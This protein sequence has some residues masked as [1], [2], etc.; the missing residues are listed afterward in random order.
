MISKKDFIKINDYLWEIPKSFRPDMRVPARIYVSEKML[1]DV[2]SEA[3]N[4]L[5][6]V[7]SLP[8]IVKYSLAMPDIH[9]GYGVVIGGVAATRYPD[10]VISP[11]GIGFDQNCLPPDAK[12]LLENGTFV[13]IKE[14]ERNWPSQKVQCLNFEKRNLENVKLIRFF[15]QYNNPF[16]YRII[17]S[18][19][20]KIEATKDHP[21]QTKE[22]MK[23]VRFLKEGEYVLLYPFKGVEYQK[24]SSKVILKEEGFIKVLKKLGK[25]ERGN[26]IIQVLNKI[27]FCNLL[28]LTYDHPSLPYVLKLMGYIFGDGCISISKSSAQI[29]FYGEREDLEEIK[30]DLEKIGFRSFI[31]SRKRNH[32]FTNSYNK[33]YKFSRIENCLRS[34]SFALATLL[35][36]LGTPYGLKTS[37]FYRVP[38]WIFKAPLWQKRL[39]LA[40]FFG[41]ELSKPKAMNKYNFYAPQLSVSKKIDLKENGKSFLKD[42]SKLLKEFGV[43]SS[44]IVE[45]PGYRY[46]GKK[47]KTTAFRLQIKENAKNLIKLFERIGYEYNQE[48]KK[49]ACL[50]ANYLRRKLKIVKLREKARREI[51]KLYKGKDCENLAQKIAKKYNNKYVSVQFLLHSLFKETRWGVKKKRGKPRVAFD[52]LS[53]EEFKKRYSYGNTGLVFDEIEKIEKLPYSNFVYDFTVN[54]PSHN[55]V[56]NNFVVSNCGVRLLKSEYTEKEIRPYLEK[57]ATEI[58][59][60]VP[61]GLGRGRAIRLSIKQINK[62]LEGGVPYLVERGYGEKEDVENCEHRGR[63]EQ[64]DASC[65]SE[66]AKNRGRDQVGT[67]G[68]GNHFCQLD[69]VEEIFDEEVAKVFGLF[70]N[71]V[72][73]FIHTGSRGLGHQNCTDYLRI[74]MPIYPKYGI[75]LPD[76]E[77]CCVPFNSPEGQRFFKAMSAACNFAWANRHMIA[78][79]VRKAWQ[80]VLGKNVKLKL[81]YDVA[82]NIAKIEE[83]NI[84]GKKMKLIVHRKGATRAFPANH[85]EIPEKYKKV[86]QPVLLPGTMGTAS[87]VCVGTEKSKE[88]FWSVNHGAGR[89]MS[90][91]KARKA[92]SGQE[93]IKNLQ[94]RGIIV[95][96]YSLR[97]LSEEAPVAYKNITEVIDVVERAGLA[98]KVAKLKPLAVIKGE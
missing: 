36:A 71:Q 95:K 56:A 9:T 61:S 29:Q 75:K 65:I 55:F 38:K 63:M 72:V 28:P 24:P 82:H 90:R 73:I 62:I 1:G 88:A 96:C 8:G 13:S 37:K 68:S 41:A 18:S 81:L 42:I 64:A 93:V 91:H 69:K 49:E 33:T 12:I 20:E 78:F 80:K 23:E 67:L 92:I 7:A 53:F 45:V 58:Q 98:K 50:A 44:S 46:Q 6:N 60:E 22:G 85:P 48:K 39:F 84:D 57:L 70:K 51:Q 25:T 32:S 76:K 94:K 26:A 4:Q 52:F 74:L 86:G 83:H 87:Y 59:K 66:R 3:L 19:Q 35:I 43:E 30:K 89:A 10:G 2:E 11:G 47:G 79:Y 15:K 21:I 17:T 40:A 16:I 27:K 97:G 14:L 5:I 54:H 31:Y 77:L 34:N